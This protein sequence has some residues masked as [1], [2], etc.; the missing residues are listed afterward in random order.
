MGSETFTPERRAPVSWIAL[1]SALLGATSIVPIFPYVGG[2]GYWPLSLPLAAI[3]PFILGLPAATLSAFIGGLIGW[4]LSPAA[5]P[6]GI[7]D[8]ILTGTM[9]A[10]AVGLTMNANKMKYYVILMLLYISQAITINL[11]PYYV[12]GPAGG[13][14]AAPQPLYFLLFLPTWLPWIVVLFTPIGFRMLP[15]LIREAVGA[16]R[17]I[18]MYFTVLIGMFLWWMPWEYPYWYVYKYPVTLTI[19][20]VSVYLIW[21][22]VFCVIIT[23][24]AIPLIEGLKRSGL[25][26]VAGAIW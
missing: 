25:P 4:V 26:K 3:A 5:Y 2:G 14:D 23:I 10:I 7:V 24:I 6:L 8:V 1:Y 15:R 21:I 22:P 12:P 11:V 9:P 13:F 20:T 19:A 17:F 16:K 18:A